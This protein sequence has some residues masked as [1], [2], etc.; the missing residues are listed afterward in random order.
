LLFKKFLKDKRG[1]ELIN[2]VVWVPL[3]LILTVV[4]SQIV[5]IGY[6][7]VI[8]QETSLVAA[9][10]AAQNPDTIEASAQQ[11]ADDFA[12]KFLPNWSDKSTIDVSYPNTDPGSEVTVTI[13]Y[14]FP[15]YAFYTNILKRPSTDYVKG[16]SMQIIEE[17]P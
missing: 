4:I 9:K 16:Q 14:I 11:A 17:R 3:L 10:S 7:Q 2:F 13:H 1:S 5:I 8:V 15:K 6:D 12:G